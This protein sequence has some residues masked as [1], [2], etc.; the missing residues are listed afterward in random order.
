MAKQFLQNFDGLPY[1]FWLHNQRIKYCG[2]LVTTQC[3]ASQ[4]A[5]NVH[6]HSTST[7]FDFFLK[8]ELP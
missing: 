4:A 8:A 1:P 2:N 3:E 6:L 7:S 5:R